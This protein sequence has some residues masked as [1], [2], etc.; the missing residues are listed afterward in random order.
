MRVTIDGD[1]HNVTYHCV[2]CATRVTF[3]TAAAG[4]AGAAFVARHRHCDQ[5]LSAV[6]RADVT[7]ES[8]ARW[9]D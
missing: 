5:P 7:V 2:V 8:P 1:R 3:A 4:P 6:P 9:K